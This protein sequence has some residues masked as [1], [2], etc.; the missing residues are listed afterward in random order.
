[1]DED[2]KLDTS[3]PSSPLQIAILGGGQIGSAF[4]FHLVQHGKHEVTIVCR[5]KSKRLSQLQEQGGI[6]TVDGEKAPATIV[7]S[8]NETI[9]YDLVLVTM[10]DYQIL[11]LLPVLK[12]S[13]AKAVQFMCLTFNP[14]R[15][16]ES[17]GPER[18]V[19]GMPF[20]QS[21]MD[22][23]GRIEI[24]AGTQNSLTG[25]AR[26]AAVF[27]A[28][29]LVTEHEEK[30]AL[31]LRCHVPLGVAFES[32]SVAGVALGRGAPWGRAYA[33]ARGV[34]ACFALIRSQGYEIY[35]GDK[36]TMERLPIFALAAMLWG[37]SKVTSFRDLLATGET[38]CGA[39]V[40][41]ILESPF[42][43]RHSVDLDAIR[44]MKPRS[45]L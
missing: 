5:P 7:D 8:L 18:T 30:M 19:L 32:V 11:P 38:E 34:H 1:M 36:R 16:Q 22:A 23:E 12:R 31:W 25:D 20:L 44:A 35:P 43:E 6:V 14:E 41:E 45:I 9:S 15:L 13:A 28:T 10:K 27:S 39:L 40:D 26:W 29:G 2:K 33:L 24:S 42:P 21:K 3:K 37:L 4:A 17:V